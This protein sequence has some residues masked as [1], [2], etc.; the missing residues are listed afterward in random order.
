[1]GRVSIGAA[2]AAVV[3]VAA[4]TAGATPALAQPGAVVVN[5]TPNPSVRGQAVKVCAEVSLTEATGTVTFSGAGATGTV[6][7]NMSGE[8]CITSTDLQSGTVTAQYNGDST[9]DPESGTATVTIEPVST[10]TTV[11]ATPDPS[12]SGQPVQ[13]CATVIADQLPE[14]T[15]PTGTVTFTYPG[16]SQSATLSAGEACVTD[17]ELTTG[18]VEATYE[19]DG[20]FAGSSGSTPVTRD[21]ADTTTAVTVT[22]DPSSLGESVEVCA[23][24]TATAPGSGT[25]KGEVNFSGP[26]GLNED[27][28]LD[29]AGQACVTTATLATGT[30]TATYSGDKQFNG[31]IGT[32]SLTVDPATT[33]TTVSATPDP[34]TAGQPVQVC[35]TV[36]VEAPAS[37][38]PTGTVTFTGAGLTD[39]VP[40]SSGEACTTSTSLATGTINAA[41]NG[42]TDF[43]VSSGATSVTVNEPPSEPNSN[44][45]QSPPSRPRNV[46]ATANASAVTV[47]WDAP[48]TGAAVTGYTVT[49]SPGPQ[50][51]TTTGA[52]TCVLGA[53]AGTTYTY[54]VVAHSDAG[55]SVPS[56]PSNAVTPAAPTAPDTPPSTNLT[57]TTTDGNITTAE[58]GQQIVFVG[59]GFAPHSTVLVTIYSTPIELGRVT[60][61]ATGAFQT[62]ITLPQ[63]LAAAQHTVVAQG[64]AP[65][66]SP[67][68]MALTVTVAAAVASPVTAG[69]GTLPVTGPPIGLL[70]LTGLALAVTG[71]GLLQAGRRAA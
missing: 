7:L 21:Q 40:L 1:M 29:G 47:D 39:T 48:A 59:T 22:P 65:D 60:T 49:A 33:K 2:L 6:G 23:T 62:P 10:T 61:D 63:Q 68:S 18:T 11:T 69:G 38:S 8:A 20:D 5:V 50:T 3:S 35:A 24:V 43:A 9:Y 25:P 13:L 46:T 58:P 53:V 15:G 56:E 12:V 54:T 4:L 64:A 41:Y 37:G 28:V 71:A 34:S 16:G 45:A 57:L 44:P 19:G 51:C 14:D 30:V 32:K 27:K 55:D 70:L 17:S 66:G 67:R 52:K 26:G 31:S 42:A 36:A